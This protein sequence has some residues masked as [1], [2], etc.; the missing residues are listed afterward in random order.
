MQMNNMKTL[1]KT[2]VPGAIAFALAGCGS[3]GTAMA[4]TS[5]ANLSSNVLQ[6]A[7]GTANLY[8][9]GTALNVVATYRQPNGNSGT[10]LNSPTLTL[11]AAIPAAL[12]AG[13]AGAGYDA[14]STAPRGPASGETTKI[15][16]TSQVA[17]SLSVTSFGQSA[18]VFGL[19]IEPYN[20][21]GQAECGAGVS[22]TATGTPFQVAPFSVPLYD[23]ASPTFNGTGDP[24]AFEPWGGPPAFLLTGSTTSVVGSGNYPAGTAGVEEGIDVFAG[25]APVPGGLYSLSVAIPTTTV[26]TPVQTVPFTLPGVVVLPTPVVPAYVPDAAGDGG[27]T[28]PFVLPAGTTSA[29]LQITDYGPST[30]M[31]P[32]C[33]GSGTGNAALG[34]GV[35]TPIY[36][37][38][39]ATASGTLTLPPLI[40]PAGAP[41]VCTAALNTAS[42]GAPTTADQ[43]AIQVIA[44][45]YPLYTASYP[46]S[47]G[48]SSPTI[49]GAAHGSDD[50]TISPA[51]CQ[52]GPVGAASSCTATLPLLK[53]RASASAVLRK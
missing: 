14:C 23:S 44:F 50:L 42:N 24:N 13:A 21:Q 26:G 8:G 36:Y 18:G 1:I 17:G 48:N 51:V 6:F 10:L 31:S 33:N 19:G 3:G 53:A 15:T 22:A 11:P 29:Y 47:L 7:V 52:V 2:L 40:G 39:Y 46:S 38:M 37:T 30:P 41:S 4:P 34:N 12:S 27:G 49:L 32:G 5:Q 35:G 43:I 28:F 16:S 20:A 9:A 45:D 25:I